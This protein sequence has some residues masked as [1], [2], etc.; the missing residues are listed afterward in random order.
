METQYSLQTANQ[1]EIKELVN[2]PPTSKAIYPNL[3][4]E[5]K[6]VLVLKYKSK[7]YGIMNDVE[8]LL[9]AKIALLKINVIT[10]WLPPADEQLEVLIDQ[11]TKKL[12]EGYSNVNPDEL[13][14]A[15]RTNSTVKDWGKIMNLALIDE[16]MA[17][18]LEARHSISRIEETAN[19]P[20]QKAIA[21]IP[22]SDQELLTAT[23][24]TYKILLNYNFIPESV[25]AYLVGAGKLVL[26][27]ENKKRIFNGIKKA[28]PDMDFKD[29]V[30]LCKKIATAEYFNNCIT[31]NK[32]P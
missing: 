25:Y 12:R 30:S 16:V 23:F 24:E 1:N 11:F 6:N 9:S 14:Y 17:P 20:P 15:F 27:T 5:E 3:T 32:Q 4:S 19:K 28:H 26:D 22:M 10:G 13:E 21:D 31:E 7:R 8:L 18:Y 29:G 2:L